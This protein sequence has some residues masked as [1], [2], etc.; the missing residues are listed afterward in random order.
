[1]ARET[2]ALETYS[3]RFRD[4]TAV[5]A[6]AVLAL[7]LVIGLLVIRSLM[8][9]V[10]DAMDVAGAL[11]RGDLTQPLGGRSDDEAGAKLLL[12]GSWT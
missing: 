9:G 11:A 1:M 4:T 7:T 10:R 12:Q 2:S 6:L 5:S 3:H 8:A